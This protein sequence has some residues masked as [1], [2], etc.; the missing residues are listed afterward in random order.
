MT[1]ATADNTIGN[2][3]SVAI[4]HGDRLADN[5]HVLRQRVFARQNRRAV[6]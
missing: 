5:D 3:L 2:M 1:A 6:E 4:T